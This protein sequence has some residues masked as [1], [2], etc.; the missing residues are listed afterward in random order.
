MFQMRDKIVQILD[1]EFYIRIEFYLIFQD[2]FSSSLFHFC[3][4]L[5]IHSDWVLLLTSRT[6]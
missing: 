5:E 4:P 6:L 2:F 1:V 3:Q